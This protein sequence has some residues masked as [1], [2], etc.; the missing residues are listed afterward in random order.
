M[1]LRGNFW[2]NNTEPFIYLPQPLLWN[3]TYTYK[4]L[5]LNY[6]CYSLI[7]DA[8]EYNNSNNSLLPLYTGTK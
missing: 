7:L 1:A 2:Q 8:I 6:S 5:L 4:I 3:V